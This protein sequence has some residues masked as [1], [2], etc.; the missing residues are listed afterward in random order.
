M[1]RCYKLTP[2]F[3]EHNM[4][5]QGVDRLVPYAYKV[6]RAWRVSRAGPPEIVLLVTRR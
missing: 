6:L 1:G 2:P 4:V 5:Y 3:R